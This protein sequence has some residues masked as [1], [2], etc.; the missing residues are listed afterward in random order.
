ME[1]LFCIHPGILQSGGE[2]ATAMGSLT[3]EASEVTGS[4]AAGSDLTDMLKGQIASHPRYPALL[5]AYLDCRKVRSIGCDRHQHARLGFSSLS[6]ELLQVGAPPEVATLLEDIESERR[7]STP[8][9]G[10]IGADP[11]LDEFMVRAITVSVYQLIAISSSA[12]YFPSLQL[13]SHDVSLSLSLF[14]SRAF[15]VSSFFQ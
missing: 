15:D 13:I 3:S 14:L 8:C 6:F 12:G 7:S 5:S 9:T 11:E 2:E 1:D 4:S 10:E